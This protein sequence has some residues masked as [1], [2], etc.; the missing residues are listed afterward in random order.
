[1]RAQALILLGAALLIAGCQTQKTYQVER[2]R[3]YA[4]DKQAVWDRLLAFLERNQI[5]GDRGRPRQRPGHRRAAGLRG[6][7]LGRLRAPPR[8]RRAP[9]AAAPG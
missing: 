8:L 9:A 2:T 7:G 4:E 5:S 3:T 1:M 6:P